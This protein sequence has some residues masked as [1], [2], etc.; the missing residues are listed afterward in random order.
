MTRS[1]RSCQPVERTIEA[2]S[3]MSELGRRGRRLPDRYRPSSDATELTVIATM[4]VP[5]TYEVRA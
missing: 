5:N 4:T 2:I 3:H 1:W